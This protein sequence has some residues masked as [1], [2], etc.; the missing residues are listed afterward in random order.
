MKKLLLITILLYPCSILASAT[1]LSFADARHLLTRTGIGASPVEIEKFAGLT[2]A[3]AV[4]KIVTGLRTEPQSQP[5]DWT[6]NAA[7]YHWQFQD[8]STSEKQKFRIARFNEMQTLKR[9]W[10]QEMIST[11]SPQT[12]RLVLFWHNHFATGFSSINNQ[13]ISMARQHLM[14]REFGSGNFRQL[15]KQIIRDPAML[16]YLDN[17]N[18]NKSKPNENL[19]RELMELFSLGEGNYTEQDVKNAARALTGYAIEGTNDQRFMFRYWAHDDSVKSI[20]GK[21]GKFNGDDLIDLIL[22]QP[23]AAHFITAKFW[24]ELVSNAKPQN[25]QLEPHAVAFRESDYDIKTLYTSLLLSDDF[26][27]KDNRATIVQSPVSLT[28]G[29]IRSTGILPSDWQILPSTLAQMGQQLFDPPNVAG[30]PGGGA[31]VTPGRLLTRLEWLK[32]LVAQTKNTRS[33]SAAGTV[34]MMA[35]Q[36]E[37]VAETTTDSQHTQSDTMMMAPSADETTG[38]LQVRL[39]SEEFD[40]HVK[41][42]VTLYGNNGKLWE[43]GQTELTGGHNTRNMG[44]LDRRNMP[45]QQITF[46]TGIDEKQVKAVEVAFHN[47][48]ADLPTAD[49]NLFVSRVSLGD[50]VWLPS[51]GKQT[52]LCARQKPEQ[53]GNLYCQGHVRIEKP[54]SIHKVSTSTVK[55]NTLRTSGVFMR[56]LKKAGKKGGQIVYTLSDVEFE[57]RY[58]NT[59]NI[60][61]LLDKNGNYSIRLHDY[62]CWP[63]CV[64]EWPECAWN[65]EFG[66]VTLSLELNPKNK[67][68]QCMY[69]GLSEADKKLARALW[70]TVGDLYNAAT[71]SHKLKNQKIGNNYNQWQIHIKKIENLLRTSPYSSDSISFEVA[72]RPVIDPTIYETITPPL[73]G[74]ITNSDWQNSLDRLKEKNDGLNLQ[75]LLLPTPG[76]TVSFSPTL[77]EVVNDLAFQLK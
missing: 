19:A 48:K 40:G 41:Y 74:G 14:F 66:T 18:S 65:N 47:D 64:E 53:Q 1:T 30:W 67:S 59:L 62:D 10:V 31:W 25:E 77:N 27:H 11:T 29:T 13:A 12:E 26:W 68:Q 2:R 4:E 44:R 21:T 34:N 16:N 70:T 55:A 5:P 71:D 51:N 39:A 42:S 9:W 35:S 32:S 61:Y 22:A 60:R 72:A 15:L 57:D 33:D 43:S 56:S 46:P 54:T 8:L 38:L 23:A 50:L 52:S 58:W 75:T 17:N 69:D 3:Q 37:N 7:P 49:R 20:F 45:W 73:P 24:H 6:Q 28:I 76:A 63:A 36:N